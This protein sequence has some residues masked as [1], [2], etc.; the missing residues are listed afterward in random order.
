MAGIGFELQRMIDEGQGLVS[1]IRSYAVAGLISS[2]PWIMTIF[3]LGI[4]SAFGPILASKD[5]FA[6]FRGL[7]TYA[8]AF[9]LIVVGVMQMTVTRRVADQLYTKEYQQVLPGFVACA[10]VVAGVQIVAGTLFC[11]G[12]GFSRNLSFVAVTLYVVVSV[13][14]LALVWLGITREFDTVLKGYGLGSLVT[15]CLTAS[16]PRPCDALGLLSAYTAGQAVILAFLLRAIVR[17]LSATGKRSFS[18]LRSVPDFPHL[19]L[20]GL[21]YN[22]GIW[23]D[24]II[25]WYSD[26]IGCH[27]WIHFHPL[28]DTC[29]YLAYLTVIPALAVNLV[30]V[31]TSFYERYRA[32]FGSILGGMPLKVIDH[33]REEMFRNMKEGMTRLLRIQGFITILIVIFA[34]YL[35]TYLDLPAPSV[36]IFRAVCIGAFFH[37]MLLITILMQLY[38][39]LRRQALATSLTFLIL[40]IALAFWSVTAGLASYGF[41][42]A[43]AALISLLIGYVLLTRSLEYYVFTSQPITAERKRSVGFSASAGDGESM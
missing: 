3:T 22:A 26:G 33:R 11:L 24:K 38:F 30:R 31:E 41:G 43:L 21:F 28:Y 20:V 12:A 19:M 9:S 25:F 17:G 7:V 5:Q 37:V 32:Y 15:F 4:I 10:S 16:L 13:T 14:W 2:G 42:Y 18:I 34:P 40:N 39:D 6:V 23:A 29:C 27:P 35:L 8:F 1:R 36:R